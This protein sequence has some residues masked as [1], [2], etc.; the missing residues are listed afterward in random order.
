MKKLI[1]VVCTV[2][3]LSIAAVFPVGAE[4]NYDLSG[5][6]NS[7][8]DETREHLLSLGADSA[9]ADT[10]S[11]LSFEGILEEISRIGSQSS[12]APLRGLI[13]VTAML[14]IGSLLSSYKTNLSADTGGTLNTVLAL[15]LSAAVAVPAAGLISQ[16]GDMIVCSSNLM[17]AYIPVIAL[18]LTASGN[19]AGSAAYYAGVLA[20][21]EGIAQLSSRII[22]PFCNMLLGLGIAGGLNSAV[23]LGGFTRSLAKTAK[24][25]L[26]FG[27]ALFTA[28]LG[29]K[30]VLTSA[31]DSL[32]GRAAK[33]A[34]SSFVPVVGSA[35]GEALRTVQGSL[36][37]LKSGIGVFVILALGVT[38][39]P[40]VLSAVMWLVTLWAGKSTAEVLNLSQGASMLE[41]IADVFRVMLAA[42]LSVM[43]VYI[44]STAMIFTMG[45]A[46]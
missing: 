8:S 36:T 14:L 35:L 29:L 13:S 44:I 3:L 25:L 18:L 7:L 6:Y 30:Q 26:G 20:M 34:L 19:I 5:V 38:F 12:Q 32:T 31:A 23:N 4:E 37:V 28:V 42:M 43:T 17:L 41:S 2:L 9:D 15:C 33:L 21:G 45:G 39:L 27:M 24:W 46:L 11:Q 16:M 22:V 1:S 10:L 40:S